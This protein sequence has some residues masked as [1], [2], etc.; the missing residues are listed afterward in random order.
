VADITVS[1]A[2][3]K[4][5]DFTEPFMENS[6]AILINKKNAKNIHSFKDLADSDIKYG[7]YKMGSTYTLFWQS[8]D[9]TIR[10]MYTHMTRH[11]D[12]M[13]NNAKDGVDK[14]NGTR[15]AFLVESSFA[16]FLSGMYCDLTFIVDRNNYFPR[17]YAIALPKDSSYLNKFDHAI[18]RLKKSGQL[19]RIK[20]RYWKDR[21]EDSKGDDSNSNNNDNNNRN[22]Y[23]EEK[24]K[25]TIRWADSGYDVSHAFDNTANNC[26]KIFVA[27]VFIVCQKHLFKYFN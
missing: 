17:Q 20:G 14:V 4:F 27:I 7:T 2:R 22:N 10:R 24:K 6:I 26:Y 23:V 18:R 5:V 8:N 9:P 15:F 16:E 3:K 11:P 13:V 19:D 12:D 25:T 21:C 1:D